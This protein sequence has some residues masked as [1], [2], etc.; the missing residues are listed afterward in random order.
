VFGHYALLY[1]EDDADLDKLFFFEKSNLVV[2]S[3]L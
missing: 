1:G 3:H 2:A